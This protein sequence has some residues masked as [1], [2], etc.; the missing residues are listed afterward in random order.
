MAKKK[1]RKQVKRKKQAERQKR[2][3]A[4]HKCLAIVKDISVEIEGNTAYLVS[5]VIIKQGPYKDKVAKVRLQIE[6]RNKAHLSK[7]VGD[8]EANTMLWT[9]KGLKS[10]DEWQQRL[11]VFTKGVGEIP[12]MYVNIT[13]KGDMLSASFYG[14]E[15]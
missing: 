13:K 6:R 3:V 5:S 7:I 1:D 8:L 15:S 2:S 10:D 11:S 12:E 14:G 9:K 4:R